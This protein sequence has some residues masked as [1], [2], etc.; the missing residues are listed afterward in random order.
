MISPVDVAAEKRARESTEGG[1]AGDNEALTLN[2]NLDGPSVVCT[3]A[4][5]KSRLGQ[6]QPKYA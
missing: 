5:G 2:L 1:A 3:D 4:G 6:Q